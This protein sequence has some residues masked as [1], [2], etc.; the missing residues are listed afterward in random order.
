MEWC[1]GQC[2]GVDDATRCDIPPFSGNG[3]C[4][5]GDCVDFNTC[6]AFNLVLCSGVSIENTC[7]EKTCGARSDCYSFNLTLSLI[8]I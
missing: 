6:T 3:F 7:L 1:A 5:L 2:A 4:F 8:H